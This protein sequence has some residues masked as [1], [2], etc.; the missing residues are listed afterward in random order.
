[1]G[2]K[3]TA[4]NRLLLVASRE[5][6]RH[7]A[8]AI[9]VD[10]LCRLAGVNKGSFYHFFPSKHDLLLESL[11]ATWEESRAEVLEPAFAPDLAPREQI[12]SYFDLSV[13]SVA[14]RHA[15][16]GIFCGCLFA[17]LGSELGPL[18]PAIKA[19][20]E[21]YL[22]RH[23]TYLIVAL[24]PA[25]PDQAPPERLAEAISSLRLGAMVQ[26][27]IRQSI[28]PLHLAREAALALLQGTLHPDLDRSP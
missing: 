10:G 17:N 8:Q 15:E 13:K 14:K 3:S 24:R 2:R 6:A 26:V 4:R 25:D 12:R 19:C 5:F 11:H 27:R 18:D 28:T 16:T 21:N 23:L 7:G 9:G 20:V 22:A 1:M